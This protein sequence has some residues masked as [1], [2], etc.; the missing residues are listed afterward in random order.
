M[1]QFHWWDY[2]NENYLDAL[3]HLSQL[4]SR[5]KIKHLGLTNFDTEHLKGIVD[6]G[7]APVSNQIQ[8][9]LIDRRPEVQMVPYCQEKDIRILPMERYAEGCCQKNT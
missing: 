9:S 8:F 6:H 5:G 4:Q 2:Q 7:F 1:L 3:A